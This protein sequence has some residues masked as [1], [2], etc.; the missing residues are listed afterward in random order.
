M[1]IFA[2]SV[3]LYYYCYYQLDTYSEDIKAV[4]SYAAAIQL[5]SKVNTYFP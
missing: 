4:V 1:A 5:I 2:S 3:S